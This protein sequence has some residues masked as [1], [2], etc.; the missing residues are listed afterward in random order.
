MSL[1]SPAENRLKRDPAPH[2]DPSALNSRPLRSAPRSRTNGRWSDLLRRTA[3][4][5][6][7]TNSLREQAHLG[8]NSIEKVKDKNVKHR[9][10]DL[11]HSA[12]TGESLADPRLERDLPRNA[13]SENKTEKPPDEL[14]VNEA[15]TDNFEDVSD[16]AVDPRGSRQRRG[17]FKARGSLAS[18]V[19]E[20]M[21]IPGHSK[22][23]TLRPKTNPSKSW[24]KKA[25][26]EKKVKIDV[27]IPSTVS[28]GTLARLL[29]VRLG[30]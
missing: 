12:V 26:I 14:K 2:Q 15:E 19:R 24:K 17:S 30:P 10:T 6:S 16:G 1:Y 11:S 3:P 22:S 28:V 13:I 20:D 21:A 8:K 29:N 7:S 23:S 9:W 4:D 18:L 25:H 27:Y 5:E